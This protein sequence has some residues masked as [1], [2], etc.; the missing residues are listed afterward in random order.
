MTE[1]IFDGPPV[2]RK[3]TRFCSDLSTREV[4]K[5][6]FQFIHFIP[7]KWIVYIKYKSHTII[8]NCEKHGLFYA[9]LIFRGCI[10]IYI[11]TSRGI[12]HIKHYNFNEQ[13]LCDLYG[14][15]IL[16]LSLK[17]S[18]YLRFYIVSVLSKIKK[19]IYE[20]SHCQKK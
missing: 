19:S 1:F 8:C 11:S 10:Y 17:I 16:L 9:G 7:S 12:F 2:Y 6:E 13:T 5:V 4:E 15:G 3:C 14:T 20:Y 18:L